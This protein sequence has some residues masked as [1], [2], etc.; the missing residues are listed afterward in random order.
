MDHGKE[1]SSTENGDV[2][3]TDSFGSSISLEGGKAY[4]LRLVLRP[5]GGQQAGAE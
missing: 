3:S 1:L 5:G 2:N 4:T